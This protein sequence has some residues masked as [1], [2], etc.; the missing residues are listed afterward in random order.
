[1]YVYIYTSSMLLIYEM[2][3]STYQVLLYIHMYILTVN[4]KGSNSRGFMW[5]YIQ[6]QYVV[7]SCEMRSWFVDEKRCVPALIG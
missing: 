1:M 6:Q 4:V 7:N 5:H 3:R 2:G